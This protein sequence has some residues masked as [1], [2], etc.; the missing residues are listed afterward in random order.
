MPNAFGHALSGAIMRRWARETARD[1]P[2]DAASAD[3]VLA[4]YHR[5]ASHRPL[6]YDALAFLGRG[7]H[8]PR[9]LAAV[10]RAA[11]HYD[12]LLAGFSPFATLWY[13]T[14]LARA[15]RRPVVLLPLFHPEDRYHHF[16][17]LYW[18]YRH[19]D[20]LLAQTDYST[21]LFRRL[22]PGSNPVQVGPAV[23]PSDYGDER[24][25]GRRF[26]ARHGLTDHQIVLTVGRKE[27]HKR[28]DLVVDA[29]EQLADDRTVLIMIGA[30][31]DHQPIAS[32]RVRWLGPLERAELLDAYDAC[33][34]FVLPSEYESFGLV[35]LEAWMRKKPVIGNATCRPVCSVIRAGH[36]GFLATT[37]AEF[38]AHIRTLLADP[39]RARAMGEAGYAKVTGRYT[40]PHVA[41]IV[42][43][44]YAEV[45]A[46]HRRA[47]VAA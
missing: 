16:R 34:V 12:V 44:V 38:A 39:A 6:P 14:V 31:V 35:F 26:R 40:W 17:S 28:Y 24:C 32:R 25:D 2:T 1:G 20:A 4:A 7:P 45:S 29:I 21:A 33:D 8:S 18:S 42:G 13:V 36:D 19:A 27:H 15:A 11:P 3:D 37:P 22:L 23:D 5:Q 9:L 47:A 10:R 43:S 41:Q 30:D 46:G